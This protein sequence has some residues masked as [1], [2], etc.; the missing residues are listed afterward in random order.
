MCFIIDFDK[1]KTNPIAK[2]VLQSVFEF[3]V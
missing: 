3:N 2:L 1:T